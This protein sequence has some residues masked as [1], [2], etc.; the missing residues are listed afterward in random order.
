[1]VEDW[2]QSSTGLPR[3]G[4]EIEFV[5]DGRTVALHGIYTLPAFYSHWAEYG[6]DRV[7]SWRTLSPKCDLAASGSNQPARALFSGRDVDTRFHRLPAGG[8]AHVA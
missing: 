6:V 1:M 2:I 5:V 3:D 4:E 8:M 7:R